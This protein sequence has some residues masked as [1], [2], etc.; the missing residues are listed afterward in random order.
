MNR[1]VIFI[2][3]ILTAFLCVSSFA[4][5]VTH[6]VVSEYDG[7]AQKIRTTVSVSGDYGEES[8]YLKTSVAIT[9]ENKSG[10]DKIKALKQVNLNSGGVLDYSFDVQ[11]PTG[12]YK[13]TVKTEG[14]DSVYKEDISLIDYTDDSTVL[15][16]L[17]N[18][19]A[20]PESLV[21]LLD[22]TSLKLV[23]DREIYS[24]LSEENKLLFADD[25]LYSIGLFT[26][27]EYTEDFKNLSFEYGMRSNNAEIIKHILE[28]YPEKTVVISSPVYNDYLGL[29]DK[30][31]VYETIASMTFT[32]D[33]ELLEAFEEGVGIAALKNAMNKSEI[34]GILKKYNLYDVSNPE[35]TVY[36]SSVTSHIYTNRAGVKAT[37]DIEAL[38]DTGIAIA[39]ALY[40]QNTTKP[41]GGGGGGGGGS[42]SSNVEVSKDV[43]K[44]PEVDVDF[45]KNVEFTDVDESH[46]AYEAV[47][48]LAINNIISGK[49]DGNYY[50]SASITRAEFIKIVSVAFGYDFVTSEKFFDDVSETDWFYPYVSAACKN[51]IVAGTG[52]GFN[53]HSQITRQDAFVILSRALK[54]EAASNVEFSD[55]E[56]IS[57]YAISHINALYEEGI[58]KGYED[59]SIKPLNNI[60]RAEAAQLIFN[61]IQKGTEG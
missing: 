4:A 28:N 46:W 41:L 11:A 60:S 3:F 20:T 54:S 56:S 40:Q 32:N 1:K 33:A 37:S 15:N 51:K 10:G 35:Y 24:H 48:T 39:K 9:D 22:N 12:D 13:I 21:S 58:I 59:N 18:R 49:G 14:T 36:E 38:A 27:S 52:K 16:T 25:F 19:T 30:T 61:V 7:A 23:L 55:K 43:V 2:T 50:P 34:T 8:G 45:N 42:Y 53:P 44:E 17:Y 26:L 31:A 29:T 57:D 47:S 6:S 5:S